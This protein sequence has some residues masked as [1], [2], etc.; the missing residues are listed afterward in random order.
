MIKEAINRILE[1]APANTI[2]INGQDYS[3]K[4]MYPIDKELR[5]E[6]IQMSI[7]T[8]LIEY[9]KQTGDFKAMPYIVHVTSPREV[10]LLSSLDADRKREVLAVATAKI[11]E[12]RFGTFYPAEEFIINV[13]AKFLDAC[14]G[15][16]NDKTVILQFAGGVKA[17]TVAEYGDNGVGQKATIKRGVAT[18]QEVEVPSPCMLV[19][20]RT[21]TE[22]AQPASSFIFRARD[23]ERLGVQLALFEADGGAWENAAMDNIRRYLKAELKDSKHVI[24]VV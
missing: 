6:R 18:M 11:P 8:G 22:V 21:F 16:E 10:M 14:P 12:F 13:Q 19:P 23:D 3:D 24:M 5:A 7:L 1:L 9:I 20:Y 2:N 17:G 4:K 15:F